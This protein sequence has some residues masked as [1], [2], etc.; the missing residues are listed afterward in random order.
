MI[1]PGSAHTYEAFLGYVFEIF[2]L[3]CIAGVAFSFLF[4]V[5]RNFETPHLVLLR[6]I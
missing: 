4:L 1:L 2:A 5:L 6:A 3:C